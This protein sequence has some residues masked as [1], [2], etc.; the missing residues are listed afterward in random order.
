VTDISI[1]ALEEGAYGV[2]VVEG[3]R[4]T[5]HRVT[6]PPSLLDDLALGDVPPEDVVRE[7]FEF[8]LEH[9]P[10]TSILNEFSLD[11]IER[12]FPEY[13]EELP[14]RLGR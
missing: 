7:S 12:Y 2:E 5:H 3:Q 4:T 14:R 6:V 10:P 13:A 8:L 9:E 1:T 11:V